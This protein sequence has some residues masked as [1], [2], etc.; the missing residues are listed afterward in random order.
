[1]LSLCLLASHMVGD[2]IVQTDWMAANKLKDAAAR[3]IHVFAYSLC[4]I[5]TACRYA[6]THAGAVAFLL[7]NA[8][9]HFV[10]D[11]RRWA[12]GDRWPPKPIL[13]DQAIHAAC[14]AALGVLFLEGPRG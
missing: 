8:A 1:M 14:L 11:S 10:V 13:V 6:P 3:A 9:A 2:Y 12:S 7:L 4:F 5:P